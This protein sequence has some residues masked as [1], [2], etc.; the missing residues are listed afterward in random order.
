[1]A[2]LVAGDGWW[3]PCRLPLA[4][5]NLFAEPTLRAAAQFGAGARLDF[6]TDADGFELAVN[7]A[8]DAA[9][10]DIVIDGAFRAQRSGETDAVALRHLGPGKKRIEVWLP[11]YGAVRLGRLRLAHASYVERPTD[12]RPHWVVYGSSI[13]QCRQASGP[14]GTWPALVAR[15]QDWNLT[16][17]GFGGECHLDR[18]VARYIGSLA[19]ASLTLELGINIYGQATF[20]A[21][22]LAPAVVGF[23]E[24]L[25]EAHPQVPLTVIT[26]IASPERE[27]RRNA[28]GLSL[29]QVRREVTRAVRWLQQAGDPLLFL[30][31]GLEIL[32]VHEGDLLTD[33]LHPSAEGYRV[34]AERIGP[35]AAQASCGAVVTYGDP[36]GPEKA[37]QI[38]S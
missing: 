34:M 15:A 23:I 6:V 29:V 11:Q 7:T 2:E 17:L 32:G 35:R 27:E 9:P 13:T 10:F 16:C 22:S 19:P 33:G 3:Q 4:T 26:P 37:S 5:Q 31:D 24:Q 14:T 25:R 28:V 20:S 18:T 8:P 1:M 12:R 36:Q 21:R 30:I 38:H